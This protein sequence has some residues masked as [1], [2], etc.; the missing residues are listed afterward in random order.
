[1]VAQHNDASPPRLQRISQNTRAAHLFSVRPFSG[2]CA[3]FPQDPGAE[4]PGT[5][6]RRYLAVSYSGGITSARAADPE[7][8]ARRRRRSSFF[9]PPH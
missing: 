6:I 1:M 8:Y 9:H 2:S 3:L 7:R 5:G 4:P